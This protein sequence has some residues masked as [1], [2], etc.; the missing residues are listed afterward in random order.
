MAIDDKK[1][2]DF[3]A[4]HKKVLFDEIGNFSSNISKTILEIQKTKKYIDLDSDLPNIVIRLNNKLIELQHQ[5]ESIGLSMYSR[6]NEDYEMLS[7]SFVGDA[8]IS[9]LLNYVIIGTQNLDA[10]AKTAFDVTKKKVDTV[11]AL[12]KVSPFRR[13]WA[14]IKNFFVPIKQE[15][16]S[17]A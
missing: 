14:R 1:I 16:M 10:Y 5:F 7:T 6:K 17:Y 3:E 11:Q 9:D 8:V 12:E 13:F 15:D 2:K 4:E